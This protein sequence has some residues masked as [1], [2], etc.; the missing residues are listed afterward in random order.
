VPQEPGRKI[1]IAEEKVRKRQGM[2]LER[3]VCDRIIDVIF[4]GVGWNDVVDLIMRHGARA[5]VVEASHKREE[6]MSAISSCSIVKL[7]HQGKR[8]YRASGR[9]GF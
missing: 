4:D 3:S 5:K 8:L 6:M 7:G 1:R 9:C 2:E